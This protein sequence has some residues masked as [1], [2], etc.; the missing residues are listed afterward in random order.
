MGDTRTAATDHAAIASTTAELLDAVNTSDVSRILAVWEEDGVFMP[1]QHPSVHGRAAL[2]AY[3]RTLFSRGRFGFTFTSST[4]QLAGDA[5]FERVTYTAAVWPAGGRSPIEE[6]GKGLHVYRR[7]IRR[8]AD[9]TARRRCL[10]A[11][12]AAPTSS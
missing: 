9:V 11:V 12:F 8:A 4:I 6:R 7:S 2:E 1:P 10:A 3:F 5:A